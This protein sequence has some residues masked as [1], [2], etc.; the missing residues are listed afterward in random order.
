MQ[1]FRTTF[2][3]HHWNRCS[4]NLLTIVLLT[5]LILTQTVPHTT[6]ILL[7]T[8]TEEIIL[9]WLHIFNIWLQSQDVITY[10]LLLPTVIITLADKNVTN[11]HAYQFDPNE[12]WQVQY[13]TDHTAHTL[14]QSMT[15]QSVCQAK[16]ACIQINEQYWWFCSI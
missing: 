8:V 12:T 3:C 1:L 15:F 7:I 4:S 9:T 16:L 6:I 13:Q 14:L 5:K 10:K 11:I 2:T